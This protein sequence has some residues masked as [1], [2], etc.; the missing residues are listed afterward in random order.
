MKDVM[1]T[2]QDRIRGSLIAGAI[3]DALGYPVEFMSRRDI[4]R[5]YGD[6]GVS[7]F[8]ELDRRG[9]AVVSDDTQMTL[10]TACGL[11]LGVTRLNTHGML[12]AGLKDYV[13]YAYQDWL[14]TQTGVDDYQAYHY[15]WI[16][17]IAELNVQ[18]AP[19][20]TCLSAL[21]SLRRHKEVSN[22]SKG[23]GGV[24]RVAPVGL[25]AAADSLVMVKDS[26]G[27]LVSR[28]PWSGKLVARLGGDC[29]A[30][31]H[32]HPLGY[33]SA[34]FM[35][36]L[37]YRLLLCDQPVTPIL[38]GQLLGTV[39]ADVRQAYATKR[40][41][42]AIDELWLLT[43]RAVTLAAD[44]S[45]PVEEAIPRLGQ[46]WTGEEALAIAVYC[47][48]RHLDS[49]EDA[50]AAAVNHDGDSDSTGAI[51]G[52]LMGAIVGYEAIPQHF[53][54]QLELRTLIVDLADDLFKG[55]PL[56]EYHVPETPD[57]VLWQQRYVKMEAAGYAPQS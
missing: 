55:C 30:I 54:Q 38:L 50:L 49:L 40:E 2:L 41:Q 44:S 57:E 47:T 19:G 52:N 14:Q 46:G 18:R 36:S 1:N 4:L 20:N 34:A 45:M 7:R 22:D 27:E 23:C 33:L 10:F 6:K 43:E 56:S 5:K 25:M 21:M 39:C 15:C 3:G 48:L 35:A 32:K 8:Q 11:L 26:H 24:M 13:A 12:G 28:H 37:V 31:T 16:R 51:C 17:D 42:Q 53:T 29:A 9:R